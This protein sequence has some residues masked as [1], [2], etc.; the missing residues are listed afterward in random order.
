MD[1]DS[2]VGSITFLSMFKLISLSED[3]FVPL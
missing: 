1:S 3:Q 2:P